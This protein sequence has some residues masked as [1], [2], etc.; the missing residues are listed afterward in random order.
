M[1]KKLRNPLLLLALVLVSA[2]AISPRPAHSDIRYCCTTQQVAACSAQGG[3]ATCRPDN[4]CR[5]L[6]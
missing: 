2:A 3:T 4:I 6:F 5:C 1:K